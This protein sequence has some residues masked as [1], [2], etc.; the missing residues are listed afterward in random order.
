MVTKKQ[1]FSDTMD[2]LLEQA[3]SQ[4]LRKQ[5]A[6]NMCKLKADNMLAWN[7]EVSMKLYP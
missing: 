1:Y 4:H 3:N 6:Q 7:R 2:L 5:H